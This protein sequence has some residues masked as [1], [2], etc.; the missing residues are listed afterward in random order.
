MARKIPY[1]AAGAPLLRNNVSQYEMFILQTRDIHHTKL[2][3]ARPKRVFQRV[4]CAARY[5]TYY[6]RGSHARHACIACHGNGGQMRVP[7]TTQVYI[8]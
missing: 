3:K 2:P 1:N 7:A 6:S 8:D 5:L 4:P